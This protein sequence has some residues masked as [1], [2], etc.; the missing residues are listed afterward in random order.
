MHQPERR[1]TA[2]E[3]DRG[4]GMR[5]AIGGEMFERP[6]VDDQRLFHSGLVKRRV[7]RFTKSRVAETGAWSVHANRRSVDHDADGLGAANEQPR[8]RGTWCGSQA[9]YCTGLTVLWD[10]G[11]W[12]G[13]LGFPNTSPAGRRARCRAPRRP[14]VPRGPVLMR[15]AAAGSVA[16]HPGGR[17]ATA[18]EY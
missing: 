8:F 4:L 9:T 12:F 15:Q 14:F 6:T 13:S 18:A 1:V 11:F 5:S 2:F 10:L 16:P 3:A 7:H 17:R